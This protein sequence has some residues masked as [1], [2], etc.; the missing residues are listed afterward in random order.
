M[1]V[2]RRFAC[3]DGLCG[4]DDCNR[5]HADLLPVA[6]EIYDNEHNNE[7]EEETDTAGD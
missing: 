2:N 3:C 4:A 5:C 6:K 1:R 7:T